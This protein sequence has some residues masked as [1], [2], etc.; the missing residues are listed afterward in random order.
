MLIQTRRGARLATVTL[1]PRGLLRL[2]EAQLGIP[3]E[4]TSF[5]TRL[6]QYLACVET[7]SHPGAFY[8]LSYQADPFSVARNLLQWRDA[9]YLAGWTG[10]VD[11]NAP[12]RLV[13]MADIELEVRESVSPGL[14]ER[15]RRVTDLLCGEPVA[16]DSIALLDPLPA[17]PAMWRQ[18]LDTLSRHQRATITGPP[19]QAAAA[20]PD[21]DLGRLQRGLLDRSQPPVGLSGDGSLRVLQ[22]AGPQ[23]SGPLLAQLLQ[24]RQTSASGNSIA[25]LAEARGS[26]LDDSLE[27]GHCPRLGFGELSPWRPVFQVLPLALELLWS[28]L[29]P[30]ALFQFLSHPVGPLP[31]RLR[32]RLAAT[33]AS[34]PGIG[35]AAWQETLEG[36]LAAEAS[37]QRKK[38]RAR[39][40]YWLH[41]PRHTPDTGIDSATLAERA[42]RVADWLRGA[43]DASDDPAQQALYGIAHN[44]AV[45][46]G[47]AVDRLRIHGR[48]PLTRDNVRRLID[49]V[50][51]SGATATD[52]EA[53]VT[54]GRAPIL[55]AAHAGAFTAA[56]DHVIWWD[57]QATDRVRPWPWS[58]G[59]RQALSAAGVEL[60]DEDSRWDWLAQAWLRPVLNARE[61]LILVLHEDVERRHPIYEQLLCVAPELTAQAV[62]IASTIDAL[63]LSRAPLA[64]TPL[65]GLQR[66]WRLPDGIPLKERELESYSS[67]D[68][69]LHSPYQWLLRY[70][71]RVEPGSLGAISDGNLLK[72]N[73]AHRLFQQYFERHPAPLTATGTDILAWVDRELPRLLGEEGALLLEA[74]RQAECQRFIV[75]TGEALVALVEHLRAA[76]VEQVAMEYWQEGEF[77]GGGLQGSIDLLATCADGSEAIVDIKWGGRRY[78]RDALLE[79]RYLQLAVYDHLR[80]GQTGRSP[81]LS[82]FIVNDA[83]MLSL[84]H[85][86]FPHAEIIERTVDEDS[87][88]YWQQVEAVWHWRRRQLEQGLVEVTVTGT[89]P[90]ARSVPPPDCPGLPETSD[91]FN[92]FRGLTGWEQGA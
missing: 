32:A 15:L 68:A 42:H 18:L 79:N 73:L 5:T 23:E 56:I 13:D 58:A 25:V 11:A 76:D 40:D 10:T 7:A 1:G 6:V 35:S 47:N 29:N 45:E 63:G 55:S 44:Q 26:E 91:D 72:G 21:T 62:D 64:Q 69:Y 89:E 16:I 22:S 75:Q 30:V 41:A 78:R 28:P 92:E 3:D 84:D 12:P 38:L 43:L 27:G 65:P 86:F 33:V 2:L 14:G 53:E 57:C 8:Y 24:Q 17:F 54:P 52:R 51:G 34:T 61:E 66:W 60:Q 71:A 9:W 70:C 83:H 48:D 36:A 77:A 80:R 74:G 31:R 90:D 82:Y 37:A 59:E 4:E 19:P 87:T 67:L 39:V 46:F 88:D 85:A 49:D 81:A 20:R 50:R